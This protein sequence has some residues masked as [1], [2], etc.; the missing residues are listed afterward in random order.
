MAV[1]LDQIRAAAERVAASHHL[2]VVEVVFAGAGKHRALQVFL[3]KDAATR[4]EL[5]QRASQQAEDTETPEFP[6]GVPVELLSGVTHEDCA[7]FATDF[8]TLLDVEELI[9]GTAEY[10]L[11]VS[12]PGLDRKLFKAEDYLRFA[13]SIVKVK[14]FTPFEG[15]RSLTGRM[16]FAAGIVTL[17]LAGLKQKGKP[18]GKKAEAKFVEIPLQEIEKANI[19]PE[20]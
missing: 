9:P 11:E 15:T 7:A 1:Q 12:S 14:T 20:I 19:V 5:M 10:V 13:G 8:G 2:E 17:D 3:E 18:G 16:S 4:T 6:R